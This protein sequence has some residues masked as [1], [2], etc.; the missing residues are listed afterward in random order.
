MIGIDIEA[1]NP[2]FGVKCDTVGL[3]VYLALL[4]HHR[5]STRRLGDYDLLRHDVTIMYCC[6]LIISGT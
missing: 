1:L 2:R 4:F 3:P 5:I 6:N